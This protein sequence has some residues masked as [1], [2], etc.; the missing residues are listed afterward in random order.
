MIWRQQLAPSNFQAQAKLGLFSTCKIVLVFSPGVSI[1]CHL[2]SQPSMA[3]RS[4]QGK[5]V[6]LVH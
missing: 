3:T 4:C 2:P 6:H 5:P 1:C